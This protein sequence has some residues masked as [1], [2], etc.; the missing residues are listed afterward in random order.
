MH[1]IRREK[2]QVLLHREPIEQDVM[3]W[4]EAQPFA[5]H[6]DIRQ[7]V[8]SIDEGCPARRRYQAGQYRPSRTLAG[9]IPTKKCRD[10]ISIEFHREMFQCHLVLVV[11]RQ[12]L[13]F[14]ADILV[15]ENIITVHYE[16]TR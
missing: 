14:H 12:I 1:H 10:H 3:L 11:L 2:R 16:R 7:Y 6:L 15:P 13:Y 8:I 5:N 9:T 4:G